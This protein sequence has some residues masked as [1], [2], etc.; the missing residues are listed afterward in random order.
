MRGIALIIGFAILAVLPPILEA[1]GQ[2]SY[3][4]YVLSLAMIWSIV[5]QSWN[6]QMGYSGIFAFGP[7]A[8]FAIGGYTTGILGNVAHISPWVGMIIGGVVATIASMIVGLPTLRLKGV[9]IALLTVAF[10]EI[11]RITMLNNPFRYGT[12]SDVGAGGGGA[13]LW[14]SPGCNLVCTGGFNGI[15]YLP[16]L[17]IPGLEWVDYRFFNYYVI[18]GFFAVIALVIWKIVNSPIGLAFITLRDSESF[19]RSL[20]V[21]PYRYKVLVFGITGF[22]MGIAGGLY[23]SYLQFISPMSMAFDTTIFLL[24][25]VAVGGWGTLLGPVVGGFV[26]TVANEF[27]LGFQQYKLLFFGLLLVAAIVLMPQGIVGASSD[28]S[29]WVKQRRTTS[30]TEAS[31][32]C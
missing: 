16:S 3:P 2:G 15:T 17:V 4:L 30:P 6:L 12:G 20:G 25:M 8:F 28:L 7:L 11:L 9:Y 5:A 1:L 24:T 29:R 27:F 10:Q 14:W 26:M 18:L 23:A 21:D 19:G 13:G 31:K 22:L 32:E